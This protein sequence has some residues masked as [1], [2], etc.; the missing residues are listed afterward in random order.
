MATGHDSRN[1]IIGTTLLAQTEEI[2]LPI[3]VKDGKGYKHPWPYVHVNTSEVFKWTCD[4]GRVKPKFPKNAQEADALCPT[5]K[6]IAL[7][8]LFKPLHPSNIQCTWLGHSCFLV[9]CNGIN[10]LTDPV[11]AQRCSPFQFVGPKRYVQPPLPLES[12]PVIHVVSVS[13][14]HYD[15]LDTAT[16][17]WL[18]KRWAPVFACPT[19][20]GKWFQS[21]FRAKNVTFTAVEHEKQE[22]QSPSSSLCQVR[23]LSWWECTEISISQ[24]KNG[25]S[26]SNS[27]YITGVPAQHWSM[28]TGPWDRFSELWGGFVYEIAV[29][30]S[31]TV[32]SSSESSV[33]VRRFYHGGDTGYTKEAFEPVGRAFRATQK[34]PAFDLAMIAIGAYSP[35][36]FMHT[37]HVDPVESVKIHRDL[38][39][40][41]LSVGM[42]WG[43]FILTDEPL[44]EPPRM[45]QQVMQQLHKYH[46]TYDE[47]SD[48]EDVLE[49]ICY[50]DGE[51]IVER[52]N[53]NYVCKSSAPSGSGG[54]LSAPRSYN[55]RF[56]AMKHGQTV[57][58]PS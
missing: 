45:L 35:R 16:I 47:L 3:P 11:F 12:L 52:K 19:G 22:H 54:E 1:S 33:I 50:V 29:P 20:M 44:D 40:P 6:N 21:V 36:W 18:Q 32:S 49:R 39:F 38:G 27:I 34:E 10:V 28:R 8:S 41:R 13:H 15:H 56:I 48:D 43:T 26:G 58:T 17:K 30:S 9:Q 57:T 24:N 14:N 2:K 51:G 55:H 46:A 31:G 4:S 42:H 53:M 5:E 37:Q 7:D 25:I 23:E